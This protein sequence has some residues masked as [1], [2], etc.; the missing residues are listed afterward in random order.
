MMQYPYI[1]YTIQRGDAYA[2]LARRFGTNERT[3]RE[4]IGDLIPG[5]TVKIYC[6]AGACR[7]GVFYVLR[8][9]DT[10]WR[11]AERFEMTMKQLLDANPY[12]NPARYMPG[13]V[14]I[15]P[16]RP[17]GSGAYTLQPG[18]RLFDVLRR[19]RVDISTFCN[20]NPG[21][22]P[23]DV[24]PGQTVVLPRGMEAVDARPRER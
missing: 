12:L 14:I 21:V 4:N 11:V 23:M 22:R 1:E 19:F 16:V 24:E 2:S 20:L 18:E 8:R 9:G 3:M 15:I 5:R 13:Q 6:P 10:L 7:C 17:G